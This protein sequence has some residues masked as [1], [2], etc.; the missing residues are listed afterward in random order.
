MPSQELQGQLQTQYNVGAGNYIMD[1]HSIKL[2]VKVKL[3]L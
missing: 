3:Y 2:K 1:K